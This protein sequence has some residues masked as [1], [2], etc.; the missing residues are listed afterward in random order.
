MAPH[1]SVGPPGSGATG[2]AYMF[3]LLH[4]SHLKTTE[5][6]PEPLLP[7]RGELPAARWSNT[8]SGHGHLHPHTFRHTCCPCVADRP[9]AQPIRSGAA[10]APANGMRKSQGGQ[11]EFASEVLWWSWG[12]PFYEPWCPSWL[13]Q[14]PVEATLLGPP[15]TATVRAGPPCPGFLPAELGIGLA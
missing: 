14:S 9:Q 4:R 3:P 12:Q 5:G 2:A 6:F 1:I 7:A 8:S 10:G 13:C 11:S 15:S